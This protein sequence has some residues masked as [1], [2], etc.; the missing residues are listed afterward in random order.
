MKDGS[1]LKGYQKVE[2]IGDTNKTLWYDL[3][4]DGMSKGVLA[5]DLYEMDGKL[6]YIIDGE[7]QSGLYQVEGEYYYFLSEGDVVR[8]MKYKAAET[9]CDL[10]SGTYYFDADGKMV[11]T[12]LVQ[13]SDGLYYIENRKLCTDGG[14]RLIGE[15]YYFVASNGRCA[16]G[17]YNCWATKCDLK[18]GTYYFYSDGKM[19]KTDLIQLSDGLYYIENYKLCT[20]GGLRLIGE[21][22]YFVAS[23]GR[24]A[25]GTYNCWATYCDLPTGTYEFGAD[26]KM[27]N[28]PQ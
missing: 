18:T 21:D 23:N 13:L 2:A 12:G 28:V 11:E 17:K 16:T 20:K 25:T 9:H 3:G 4:E 10:A 26:G 24:C 1:I 5:E 15:D 7:Q 8:S 22:Y 27:L 6:Y 19:V 14:L